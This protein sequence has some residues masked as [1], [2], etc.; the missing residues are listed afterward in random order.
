MVGLRLVHPA[1]PND[2]RWPAPPSHPWSARHAGTRSGRCRCRPPGSAPSCSPAI[3]W[4]RS[5]ARPAPGPSRAAAAP[6]SMGAGPYRPDHVAPFARRVSE[7]LDRVLVGGLGRRSRQIRRNCPRRRT[8]SRG[9]RSAGRTPRCG[10][11]RGRRRGAGSVVRQ[12][13]P[14]PSVARKASRSSPRIRIF[15]GG[16]SRSGSSSESSA[17]SRNGA[18][19]RPIGVPLSLRVRN[20]LSAWLSISRPVLLLPT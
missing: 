1:P 14:V 15:F 20:S 6:A 8:S 12:C 2:C 10:R 4:R 16:P 13:R 9:R 5:A 19:A 3:S 17:G 11:S 7:E 18:R